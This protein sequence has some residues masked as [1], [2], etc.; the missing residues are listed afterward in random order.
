MS[1][2]LTERARNAADKNVL[3]PNLV[4]EI[5]GVS[6]LYGAV[7]VLQIIRVGDPDLYIGPDW[8][9]GGLRA[10]SDQESIV[11]FEGTSTSIN[12]K[13]DID[14]ASGST[15]SQMSIALVDVN[16]QITQLIT[17]GEIVTDVLGRKATIWLGFGSTAFKDDYVR[18]FRG[19]IDDVKSDSGKVTFTFSH[20]D[21]KKRQD[22]FVKA[23]SKLDGAISNSQT[24]IT[25]ESV[26]NFMYPITGPNGLQD[27]SIKY[28]VRIEDE[29]IFYTGI[30]GFNLTGCTRGALGTT[31]VSHADATDVSSFL[32]INGTAMD[33][34]LKIMLSGWNGYYESL[35]PIEN[36]N[37]LGDATIVDNS[38]FFINVDVYD[39]L[40]VVIGD[41]VTTVGATNGANNVTLKQISQVVKTLDGSYIV[42][43]DVTFVTELDST[44]T[45]SFRSQYD[46]FHPT[47][48]LGMHNNEVDILE[49]E[50]LRRW[51][52]SSF[53]YEFYFRDTI[54]GKEFIE[55]QIYFPASA[56][57]LPRKSQASVGY[58]I[59]PLPTSEV[60]TLNT[61]NVSQPSKLAIRRS[62]AKNFFNT[63]IYKYEED[64]LE[65]NSFHRGTVTQDAPSLVQIPVGT[66]ALV[67]EAKGIRE[68]LSGHTNSENASNRRIRKYK[69]AAEY[70][71]GIWVALGKSFNIEIGDIL[72]VNLADLKI[73]DT[74]N[75]TR[76]GAPRLF[77]VVNK[78]LDIRTGKVTL[79]VVDT[80]YSTAT[81]YCLM[82]PSSR[83]N[84]G[85]TT[86][87]IKLK[88]TGNSVF[89]SNEGGKWSRYIGATI[90]VRSDDFTTRNDTSTI[91]SVSGNTV[92]L[93][94]A[95]SFTPLED[96][97]FT[98][99][100]YDE[101]PDDEVS[102]Q[103][104]LIYGFMVP[105]SGP[106]FGDGSMAYQ[107]I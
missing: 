17:P 65:E 20:P 104:K 68:V 5:E 32:T 11:T 16:E 78:T 29:V 59:G 44:A 92:T 45:I 90:R 64:T 57:S 22:I 7:T 43:D 107:M 36:F 98:L 39:E 91:L 3:T 96:D 10:I 102:A 12:Q 76:S 97:T 84:S 30:S 71:Q 40:G 49:H 21:Q 54:G 100:E 67:I 95:L 83:I 34:A 24:T 35:Y 86:T 2:T 37:Q 82:S 72:T 105:G 79:D 33:L 75:A 4:L 27:S 50:K 15:V 70:I 63:I 56:F 28:G 25:L 106:F 53:E 80:A 55:E 61:T 51:F 89:G 62:I 88:V 42:V 101:M 60:K 14:K 9:I 23:E 85:S 26:T 8:V 41:Y 66:R 99:C 87:S 13:L 103:L 18:I 1:L 6:T 46:T 77:E 93:D 58:H 69:F 47:A 52:L 81:R 38:I 94:S 19:I 74:K 73:S 48:G 31:A